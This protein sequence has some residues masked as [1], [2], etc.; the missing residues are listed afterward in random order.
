[1]KSYD[2]QAAARELG[3]DARTLRR[4]LR[5]DPSYRNAGAGGRYTFTAQEM[6]ALKRHFAK[7][8]TKAETRRRSWE[9]DP[10]DYSQPIEIP[11]M[12]PELRAKIREQ[13]LRLE[14]RLLECGLHISQLDRPEWSK[15]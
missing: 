12:T 15:K 6:A 5:R 13:E 3:T 2:T 1:M 14:A 7:W 10:E 4:F 11:P 9:P 8:S